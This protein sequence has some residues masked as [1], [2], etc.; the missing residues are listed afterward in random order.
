MSEASFSN[1]FGRSTAPELAGIGAGVYC[2]A[3]TLGADGTPLTGAEA[4]CSYSGISLEEYRPAMKSLSIYHPDDRAALRERWEAS[5]RQQVAFEHS[6]RVRRAD[7]VY[8]WFFV[9]ATPVIVDGEVAQ[10]LGVSVDM[11][12]FVSAH[13]AARDAAQRLFALGSMTSSLVFTA[14]ADGAFTTAQPDW[15]RYTGQTFDQYAGWGRVDVIH[16]DFRKDMRAAWRSAVETGNEMRFRGGVWHAAS[17]SYRS[18]VARAVPIKAADGTV[19]E[20][21][22][23]YTDVDVFYQQLSQWVIDRDPQGEQPPIPGK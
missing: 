6:H 11:D 2:R 23:A 17:N 7:G 20:W 16:P 22:G 14:D 4:V 5:F 13:L 19:N 3:W 21:V 8:R 10:W 12:G 1:R 9:R 18:M 15:E